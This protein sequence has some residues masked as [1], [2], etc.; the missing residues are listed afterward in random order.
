MPSLAE[1][2]ELL[3][4]TQD[5]EAITL[6]VSILRNVTVESIEPYLR[7][8]GYLAGLN[9]QVAFGDYDNVVQ[10]ALGGNVSLLNE[11]T[12]AVLIFL[13]LGALSIDI[14]RK[15]T[16]LSFDEVK[17]EISRIRDLV[18]SIVK[19]VRCQTDATIIWHGFELPIY[20]AYGIADQGL[21]LGGNAAIEQLNREIHHILL[22]T[23]NSYCSDINRCV[24]EIGKSKF[25]DTRYWHIGRAPYARHGVECIAKQDSKFLRAL[26]GKNKKCLL[27]DCDNTLWG[28]IIGEDGLSN[29]KLGKSYPG[30]C[31][32]EFQQAV[33]SLY[34]RGIIVGLCS[35][36]NAD[37]V[38]DVINNHPDMLL[39]EEHI[40]AYRINWQ[41]KA[42]NIRE[43]AEEL[44]IG[45]DSIVF[46]DDSE[47][48]I[49]L[50]RSQL[51]EVEAIWLPKESPSG[52]WEILSS[53]GLFD[54][55][56]VSNEDKKRGQMYKADAARKQLR[57]QT[58]DM[59]AYFKTLEMRVKISF[60]DEFSIPRIAQLTQKTNQF[61]LTT[62][63]Y[64]DADITRLSV[65]EDFDVLCLQLSDKFSDLGIVGVSILHYEGEIAHVDSLLLSCRVLGRGVESVLLHQTLRAAQKRGCKFVLGKYISTKKNS[66]VADF[67][68]REGFQKT[69]GEEAAFDFK[70]D[71]SCEIPPDADYFAL[72]ESA[73]N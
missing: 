14:T 57:T 48:E 49:N 39:R 12:D 22:D 61:N 58:T 2:E 28:G 11:K 38:F 15:I 40:A 29:I 19:G 27:L 69:S 68:L 6:Q 55:L 45:L 62:R 33:V 30:S 20:P 43:I 46:V 13:H 16:S 10:D 1:I 23:P 35:K 21:L 32:Y 70:W 5:P 53:C 66:Q 44:N 72:V 65:G 71:L 42:S 67:Y 64:D 54:T 3:N 50:I 26:Y 37:D 18:D 7:Y 4:R 31:Y 56:T 59:L 34:H 51:P 41:D 47:F 8:Y 24:L 60:A 36:N 9:V 25:Y 63:R 17:N 52:Y 73:V